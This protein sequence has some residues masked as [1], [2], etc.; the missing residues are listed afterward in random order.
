MGQSRHR[1]H[2]IPDEVVYTLEQ[3]REWMLGASQGER[4]LYHI[5]QMHTDRVVSDQVREIGEYAGL[6]SEFGVIV[7]TQ[8]RV[9]ENR[10]QYFAAKREIGGFR[11][12]EAVS[13]GRVDVRTYLSLRAVRDRP[14]CMSAQ[15]SIRGVFSCSDEEGKG[16][17]SRLIEL[18]L[19]TSGQPSELTGLGRKAL[20]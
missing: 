15:K 9:R 7:I 19:V 10:Y 8:R 4:C 12:P 2:W 17:L 13:R 14:A 3:F 5:G 16:I 6:M 11:I 20:L 1:L 18:D